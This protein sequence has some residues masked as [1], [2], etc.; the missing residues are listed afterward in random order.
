M[1]LSGP[2]PLRPGGVLRPGPDPGATWGCRGGCAPRGR[3]RGPELAP[4][5]PRSPRARATA[6][7]PP[8]STHVARPREP[9]GPIACRDPLPQ[10]GGC[11]RVAGASGPQ[12]RPA[13]E[14]AQCEPPPKVFWNKHPHLE[15]SGPGGTGR[16]WEGKS[17]LARPGRPAAR[18]G[19][20]SA[21]TKSE[22][23]TPLL[24]KVT[25]APRAPP[26]LP[27]RVC[28][29]LFRRTSPGNGFLIH[30]CEFG[31][32]SSPFRKRR[33]TW[34]AG[35]RVLEHPEGSVQLGEEG[36]AGREGKGPS[37]PVAFSAAQL[38]THC[39]S[40][41]WLSP[42]PAWVPLAFPVGNRPAA[43]PPLWRPRKRAAGV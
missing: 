14:H 11:R 15:L 7:R 5:Q 35:P 29:P 17:K 43:G 27:A 42:G 2:T 31:V 28:K 6:R 20:A 1:L 18:P 34:N 21:R 25:R 19:F 9:E 3:Q 12:A 32:S 36:V 10:S 4:R 39:P 13:A 40:L 22:R 26:L 16:A 23:F 33:S 37:L 41:L 8:A 30:G 24:L 38:S